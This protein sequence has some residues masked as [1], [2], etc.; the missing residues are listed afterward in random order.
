MTLKNILD[1]VA[2]RLDN[3]APEARVRFRRFANEWY[4]RILTDANIS[5]VR[6]LETTFA[7]VAGTPEYTLASTVSRI[8][9][10]QDE[11]NRVAL[12][13]VSMEWIRQVDP[14]DTI[15]GNPL[16]YAHRSDRKIRLWPIPSS[17]ITIT[18]DADASVTELD[19]DADLP[20]VPEDFHYLVSTGVRVNEAQRTGDYQAVQYLQNEMAQGMSRLRHYMVSRRRNVKNPGKVQYPGH[21]RLGGWYPRD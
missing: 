6:D 15:Q 5:S 16:Y 8:R 4:R 3:K 17:I 11:T 14:G 18:I 7:T 20:L 13:E 19:D 12:R 10:L 21:S 1:D 2:E 9:G